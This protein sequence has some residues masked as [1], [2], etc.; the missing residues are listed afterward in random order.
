[1]S[2]KGDCR[3]LAEVCA[4]LSAFQINENVERHNVKDSERSGSVLRQKTGGNLFRSF[5]VNLQTNK[6]N[7]QTGENENISEVTV[8]Q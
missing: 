2:I 4:L 1:M 3:G 8:T 6:S 7:N 5:Y